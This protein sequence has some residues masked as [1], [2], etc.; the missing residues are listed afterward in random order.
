MKENGINGLY[1]GIFPKL[2]QTSLYNAVL[3][4][5]YEKLRVFMKFALLYYAGNQ[6]NAINEEFLILMCKYYK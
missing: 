6:N 3:M 2:I 4:I 5:T 1:N